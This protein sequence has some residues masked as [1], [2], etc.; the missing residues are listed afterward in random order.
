M[1][2]NVYL[3]I[4]PSDWE[5]VSTNR[6]PS[7]I[8]SFAG[9]HTRP[10]V[11]Q[12]LPFANSCQKLHL[13]STLIR[14]RL[15]CTLPSPTVFSTTLPAVRRLL[16][17]LQDT[18]ASGSDST[19]QWRDTSLPCS[20]VRWREEGEM[21]GAHARLAIVTCKVFQLVFPSEWI[22]PVRNIR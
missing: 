4:C 5:L 20:A 2:R 8:L 7:R 12:N 10:P 14:V 19:R 18:A 15:D 13:E 9:E 6:A 16:L 3:W 17:K 21:V 1:K 11:R 22:C